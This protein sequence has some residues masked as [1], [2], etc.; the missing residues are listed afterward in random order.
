[1]AKAKADKHGQKVDMTK[2][3]KKKPTGAKMKRAKNQYQFQGF[4]ERLKNLDVK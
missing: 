2:L 1:M 4:Y 3:I